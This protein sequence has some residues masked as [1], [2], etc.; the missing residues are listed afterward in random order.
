MKTW[1][2]VS[3]ILSIVMSCVVFF[4]SSLAGLGNALAENGEVGG[5]AGLLVSICMLVG[6]IVSIVVRNGGKGGA[7]ALI[8]IFGLAA[9]MGFAGAGSYGDLNIWSGWCLICAILA[10]ISL[11]GKK[12]QNTEAQ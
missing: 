12:K 5:S 6:G 2:L 4:Q 11:F 1:R 7:I 8:I 9:L 10:L 3:G